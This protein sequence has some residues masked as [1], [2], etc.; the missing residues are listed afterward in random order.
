VEFVEYH[1]ILIDFQETIVL[2][3]TLLWTIEDFPL[4]IYEIMNYRM[5]SKRISKIA[6]FLVNNKR[7]EW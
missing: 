1:M 3:K 7:T 4:S 6:T 2:S 5:G